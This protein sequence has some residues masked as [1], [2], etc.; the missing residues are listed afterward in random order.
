VNNGLEM[1]EALRSVNCVNIPDLLDSVGPAEANKV[2]RSGGIRE[3]EADCQTL[4]DTCPNLVYGID[5]F[6]GGL[7]G[8]SSLQQHEMAARGT[9][10]GAP[11]PRANIQ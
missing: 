10:D 4:L 11:E 2:E 3:S 7:P 5:C 1:F 6:P 9:L 8:V